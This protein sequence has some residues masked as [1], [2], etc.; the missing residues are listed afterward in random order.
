LV[1]IFAIE[2]APIV[3]EGFLWAFSREGGKWFI[4]VG[5]ANTY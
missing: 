4:G 1:L 3:A 5:F 2:L